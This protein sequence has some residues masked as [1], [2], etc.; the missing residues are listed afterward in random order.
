[1][2]IKK[3]SIALF[4]LFLLPTWLLSQSDN[5]DLSMIYKIKQEGLKNSSIEDLA[6]W[7][8]D[9]VGPRLTASTGYNR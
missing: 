6:F 4:I 9:F 5:V 8:T 3:T 7:L 2:K 1:M